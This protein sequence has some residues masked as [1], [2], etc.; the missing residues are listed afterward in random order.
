MS[1]RKRV[2]DVNRIYD[3][4]SGLGL[5]NREIWIRHIYP[6]FGISE[7][8]FYNMLKASVDPEKSI[9]KD[10]L[11]LFDFTDDDGQQ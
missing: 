5:S 6:K 9:D 1:Y 3:Q 2:A 10:L 7:R 11:S 4:F 8:T